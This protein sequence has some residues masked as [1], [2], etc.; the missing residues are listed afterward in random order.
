VDNTDKLWPGEPAPLFFQ[1]TT[2]VI[3]SPKSHKV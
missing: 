1:I 3:E 2:K